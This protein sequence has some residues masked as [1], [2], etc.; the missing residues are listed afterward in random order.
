MNK[1]VLFCSYK[2]V[3]C[4]GMT[5]ETQ[6]LGSRPTRACEL[7]F[8]GIN[9]TPLQGRLN[10][11]YGIRKAPLGGADLFDI[12]SF[13]LKQLPLS[14]VSAGSVLCIAFYRV[15]VFAVYACYI[16]HC[17][18]DCYDTPYW[19]CQHVCGSQ[20]FKSVPQCCSRTLPGTCRASCRSAG[21]M[22][23]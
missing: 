10:T 11:V 13:A 12:R 16:T 21:E 23:W 14:T 17:L 18:S 22:Y 9:K 15:N 2:S 19:I 20:V 4:E 8:F 5:L 1:T 3:P 6:Y 7:K